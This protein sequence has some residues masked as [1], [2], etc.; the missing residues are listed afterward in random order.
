MKIN[1]SYGKEVSLIRNNSF[2]NEIIIVDGQGRSG[3]NLISVLLSTMS[4][5]E[6]MRLDSQIDY[7]PRY[8]FLRKMSLD[9]AVAALKTE[10]DEKYYYNL[11]SRDVN[12]RFSD[13]SGVMKQGK[14]FEYFKRLLLSAEETAITRNQLKSPIFQEMTHDGLHVAKLYFKALGS[15]LKMIH[16][17]RDPVM[18]IFEQNKRNFGSRIGSDPR[19]FQL[20]YLHGKYPIS[21]AAIG[22]EKEYLKAN[23][24]ER[25]V[26][27][28]DI[29]FRLNLQGFTHLSKIEQEKVFFLEFEEFVQMP[30]LYLSSLESFIGESFGK[31]TKRI[32]KREKCPRQLKMEERGYRINE[33]NEHLSDHFKEIFKNLV[34]DY[35]SKPW[36]LR[37]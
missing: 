30:S 1:S 16:V 21:I 12:F 28:V 33:I 10:F 29:M 13:Y 35:D 8:Y 20:T 22:R 19:E 15:R 4:R 5:V 18:N 24:L 34:I 3:K 2:N 36:L 17:L 6:K 11:I 14:R 23:S 32:L 7:I 31:S 26:M 25:L 27:I 9:A 37:Y